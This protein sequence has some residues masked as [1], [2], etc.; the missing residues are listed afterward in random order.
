VTFWDA[1]A[2]VPLCV[3]DTRTRGLR[4]L[5]REQGRQVVWWGT[6][7]EVHGALARMVREQAL[8][9]Q[10]RDQA[11][12]RLAVLRRTW[13]EVQPTER[14][15][16]LAEMLPSQFNLR[17]GDALQLAAALVWSRERPRGRAFVCLDQRLGEAADRLG[18]SVISN[19]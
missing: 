16:S 11:A 13:F 19:A 2:V 17:A 12:A 15:R 18:Y 4:R 1:S 9:E 7:V 8:T 10:A 3:R 6:P 14:V 5:V